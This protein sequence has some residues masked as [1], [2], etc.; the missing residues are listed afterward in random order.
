[1]SELARYEQRTTKAGKRNP[2]PRA[3]SVNGVI[4]AEIKQAEANLK[5]HS[6]ELVPTDNDLVFDEALLAK[7]F[8]NLAAHGMTL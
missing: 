3:D 7:M 4:K 2:S 6:P 1:M 8:A 5:V